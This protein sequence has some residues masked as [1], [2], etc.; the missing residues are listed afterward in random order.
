MIEIHGKRFWLTMGEF[1][2]LGEVEVRHTTI[3]DRETV[4][5]DEIAAFMAQDY[6]DWVMSIKAGQTED[7]GTFF[8]VIDGHRYLCRVFTREYPNFGLVTMYRGVYAPN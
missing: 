3:R 6:G 8:E 2:L 4:V 1:D 5:T 7:E